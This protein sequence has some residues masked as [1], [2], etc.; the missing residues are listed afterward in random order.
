M[1]A[2]ECS[3][4]HSILHLEVGPCCEPVLGV[5][6]G[7][8]ELSYVTLHRIRLHIVSCPLTR[9]AQWRRLFFTDFY[10]GK[11]RRHLLLNSRIKF[12]VIGA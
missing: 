10:R 4:A 9:P 8:G 1:D 12:A 7:M 2:K 6:E 11:I 5:D 3:V